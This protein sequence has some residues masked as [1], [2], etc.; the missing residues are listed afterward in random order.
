ME[1]AARLVRLVAALGLISV[2]IEIANARAQIPAW[3]PKHYENEKY[4][5]S[6]DL[7]P[8]FPACVSEHTNHGIFIL[9]SHGAQCDDNHEREPYVDVSANY[10][11]A[12]EAHTPSRLARFACGPSI[13]ELGLRRVKWLRGV[14]LG[15]RKAA[16]CRQYFGGGR[17]L[18]SIISLRK[19]DE[20]VSNWIEVGAYLQTT[21]QRYKDDMRIFRSILKTVWIHPDGPDD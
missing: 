15:G 20:P 1:I 3:D 16:G 18:V 5:F 6:V 10:N 13:F 21:P 7:P 8:G 2:V 9:L 14:I 4:Q 12:Y 17:I 19:T 11:V